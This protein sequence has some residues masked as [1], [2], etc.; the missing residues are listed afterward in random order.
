MLA[1]SSRTSTRVLAHI[2]TFNATDTI[3]RVIDAL[4]LQTRLP[5]S[6]LIVDNASIDGTLDRKFPKGVTVIRNPL[7]VG[8]SGAIPTGFLY[9]L[10]HDFDWMWILDHDSVPRPEALETLLELYNG[11]PTSSQME[12]GFISCLPINPDGEALHGRL[13]TPHGRF[14][15]AP[16]PEQRY[17]MCHVKVWSGCLYRLAA[18]RSIGLPNPEYFID[19]GELEYAYRLMRAG[20]K[21]FIHRDAILLHNIGG[22]PGLAAKRI[23]VGPITLKLYE[24]APLRCYYTLRNTLYFT[25]YDSREGRLWKI[26]ELWRLRSRPGRSLTSGIAWQ[27]AL[28]TL[29]FALRP[30]THG[31]QVRACLRGIW[32]GLT[33]NVVARY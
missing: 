32:D 27:T 23:K 8:P 4:Q 1:G 11:W 16:A 12:T 9:S 25:L 13:F 14:V 18:V 30:R 10:E 26:R 20:Y 33:G 31:A 21:S 15:V 17:Y 29:N 22:T 7:N 5:D 24:L 19:R 2:T 3:D 28:L 6:I